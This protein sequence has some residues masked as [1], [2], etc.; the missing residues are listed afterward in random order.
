[1]PFAVDDYIRWRLMEGLDDISLT[2][3]HEDDIEAF[4]DA[5]PSWKPSTLVR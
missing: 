3:R 2:L 1:M 5:R 4:E